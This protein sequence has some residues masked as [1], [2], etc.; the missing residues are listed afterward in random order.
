[1]QIQ[2]TMRHGH[3]S[4]ATQEK[5][6]G[7]VE[8]LTRYFERLTLIEVLVDLERREVPRIDLKVAAEHKHDFVATE[9]SASLMAALDGVIH[10]LEQQ[11]RKYKEKVQER[12][13]ST[14]PRHETASLDEEP[15][16]E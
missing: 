8:R 10:K 16:G 5:I 14:P 6:R 15:G 12:H 2:I 11:L 13:R 1:M 3:V 7:K 9:Q 4:D